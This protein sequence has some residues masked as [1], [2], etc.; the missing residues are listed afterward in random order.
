MG[1]T[2]SAALQGIIYPQSKEKVDDDNLSSPMKRENTLPPSNLIE[3][4]M[5][6]EELSEDP[7]YQNVT[8]LRKQYECQESEFSN[9]T[10]THPLGLC[11]RGIH[12][13]FQYHME[14]CENAYV[15][16]SVL[17]SASRDYIRIIR[18][19]INEL[20]ALLNQ[21]ERIDWKKSK[22]LIF[23]IQKTK[24][25]LRL[26]EEELKNIKRRN[27]G[28]VFNNIRIYSIEDHQ[29]LSE[30]VFFA[31]QFFKFAAGTEVNNAEQ[32]NS[33]ELREIKRFQSHIEKW[34]DSKNIP[35]CTADEIRELY[36]YHFDNLQP[37]PQKIRNVMS[38]TCQYYLETANTKISQ[39]T[40]SKN[41]RDVT[42][43]AHKLSI[44]EKL[45]C[46]ERKKIHHGGSAQ[47][48]LAHDLGQLWRT[49]NQIKNLSWGNNYSQWN[50]NN[51]NHLYDNHHTPMNI[52]K[53]NTFLETC[54]WF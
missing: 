52:P 30:I 4:D 44:L 14:K 32:L 39:A 13:L 16:R 12:K 7:I 1:N 21:G 45:I 23:Q 37:N 46:E 10:E 50:E 8:R 5:S 41:Y 9:L 18:K 6:D 19:R 3:N 25:L 36:E 24:P 40:R 42:S 51:Y 47:R 15:L 22:K 2:A 27:D 17:Y 28:S 43:F 31:K 20:Y 53:T 33:P 49:I 48:A 29:L 38:T 35:E 54:E 34:I 26:L 11:D